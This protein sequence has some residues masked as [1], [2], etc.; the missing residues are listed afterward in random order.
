MFVK[1]NS[2]LIGLEIREGRNLEGCTGKSVLD[3]VQGE[4]EEERNPSLC[5]C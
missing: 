5:I 3:L 2:G 1:D 4:I